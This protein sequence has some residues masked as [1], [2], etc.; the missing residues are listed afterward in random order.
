MGQVI[1]L[2]IYPEEKKGTMMGWYGL[3]ATA[4][5]IIAPTIAGLLVDTVGW[6]YIFIYTMLVMLISLVIAVIHFRDV[7]ELQEIE[8]DTVSFILIRPFICF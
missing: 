3:V 2:S 8:F 6:K 7:L 5:P 1:I 4:A